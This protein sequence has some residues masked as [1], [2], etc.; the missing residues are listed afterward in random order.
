MDLLNFNDFKLVE[1]N[2]LVT[3]DRIFEG[4][5]FGHMY[6]PYEDYTLSF[7]DI[8]NIMINALSGELNKEEDVTEKLDGLALS[9]SWK[10]GEL[11]A[12]R[13][14]GE[15]KNAGKNGLNL[16]KLIEKFKNR[17][18]LSDSFS[19]A[20]YDLSNAIKSIG[21]KKRYEIFEE[22]EVFMH[23]EIIDPKSKNVIN[24]DVPTIIF[25]TAIKYDESGK[26]IKEYKDR[27][28]FLFKLVKK[29]NADI[30]KKFTIK[31][32]VVI[33]MPKHIDFEKKQK[34]FLSE[35][36]KIMKEYR[37]TDDD[38]VATYI[39]Y[40]WLDFFKELEKKGT[41]DFLS[42]EKD[43]QLTF[44]ER[45][46]MRWE[47]ENKSSY[48]LGE[49]KKDFAHDDKTLKWILDFDKKKYKVKAK[50][51]INPIETLFLKIGSE[52]LK[53]IS[54]FLA[55]NPDTVVQDIRNEI[56]SIQ[57]QLEKTE[58]LELLH[59]LKYEM[60]RLNSI[61]GFDAIV[62]SEGVVFQYKGKTY[63]LTG[64][65]AS[66]NQILGTIKYSL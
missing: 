62:P 44:A 9:I 28:K 37:L 34:Y 55:A 29:V 1:S 38:V 31:E 66:V 59:K 64:A 20:M 48:T 23:L 49:I 39:H 3:D 24:Y 56:I 41:V 51:F 57:K 13:N 14:K 17:G 25:H 45:L 16:E 2:T 27:A 65:F 26:P 53:N 7:A 47:M 19:F 8:K 50:E 5:A 32:P 18:T 54:D 42:D 21:S 43:P 22:G 6:H 40:K 11:I 10:N 52:V 35:I 60:A 12:A 63:K 4:G 15:F 61:G 36:N 46:L 58:N 30:Q 33:N